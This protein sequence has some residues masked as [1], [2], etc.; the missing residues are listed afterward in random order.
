MKTITS[1]L[2]LSI[3]GLIL[4][5]N[6]YA[7][8]TLIVIPVEGSTTSCNGNAFVN[9]S[10]VTSTWQWFDNTGT[11]LLQTGGDTLYNRCIGNYTLKFNESVTNKEKIVNFYIGINP[12]SNSTLNVTFTTTSNT[13]TTAGSCNGAVTVTATGGTS[14]YEF[15]LNNG[16]FGS[17][18]NFTA[19][20]NGV[21][22][23]QVK[24]KAGCLKNLTANIDSPNNPCANSTLSAS[25]NSTPSNSTT[26]IC[27]G[28]ITV[29]ANGGTS[30]YQYSLDNGT[31]GSINNFT[32]ICNGS[33]TIQIKDNNGCIKSETGSIE[34][35]SNNNNNGKPCQA[36]FKGSPLDNTGLN[37]HF[38]DSS[39]VDSGTITSYLWK[40]DGVQVGT[41][42][43][44][45]H[46][47]TNGKHNM[48][49]TIVTSTGCTDTYKDSTDFPNFGDKCAN[50]TL[51]VTFT[52]TA[53]TLT[54]KIYSSNLSLL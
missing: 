11:T 19:L 4:S 21:Q 15:S 29:T 43:T 14:P 12:C 28:S 42:A 48:Y 22:N 46:I 9:K 38:K 10:I 20:C 52:T 54:T 50:S 51:N 33:H 5:V 23:V 17:V 13:S 44:I 2:W 3:L 41:N 27:N 39:R 7:Q 47:F 40:S 8:D 37:F 31:F 53:N 1:K 34:N 35:N 18:S 26:S 49:L 32:A 16:I 24:D 6:L 25:F 45:D 30:P 36:N